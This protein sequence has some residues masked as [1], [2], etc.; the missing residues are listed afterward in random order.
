[1]PSL[2][3]APSVL[4]EFNENGYVII[5]GIFDPAIDFQPLIDDYTERLGEIS[6]QWHRE[7][8]LS[9][10]FD[11]LPF[12]QKLIRIINETHRPWIDYFNFSLPLWDVTEETP[13]HFPKALLD[14]MTKPQLLDKIELFIGPEITANPIQHVRIKPP[15]R[16]YAKE[17]QH[18][19]IARTNWHQDLGVTI[20]EANDTNLL[21]VW[22]PIY[23]S[24]LENGSLRMIPGSHRDPLVEHC[25]RTDG[26]IEIPPEYRKGDVVTVPVKA[27]DALFLHKMVKHDSAPNE[28]R[29]QVRWSYDLRYNPTDQPTGRPEWPGFVARS[30]AAPD[31]VDR[32]HDAIVRRWLDKRTWMAETH[33]HLVRRWK[34]GSMY[35]GG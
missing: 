13:F 22:I 8:I 16:M 1:M 34:G 33:A 10:S 3:K 14:I 4:D 26:D 32:D 19:L 30:H 9:S 18:A 35:C 27:G 25:P 24:T 17:E 5:K 12:D 21:T 2:C 6:G 23:D 11:E 20:E 15:Q 31:S 28:T 29:D 7:G